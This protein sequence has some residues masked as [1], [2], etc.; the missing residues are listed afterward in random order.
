MTGRILLWVAVT[1][2]VIAL[3]NRARKNLKKS[4]M[5][6]ATFVWI[7]GLGAA[8]L[9]MRAV[10]LFFISHLLLLGGAWTA[11]MIYLW[12]GRYIWWIFLLPAA[13]LAIF[14]FSDFVEGSRYN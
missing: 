9:G 8:G 13:T 4:L 11:L 7:S 12:K 6:F 3:E 2:V 14:V 1:L 5:A 10:P